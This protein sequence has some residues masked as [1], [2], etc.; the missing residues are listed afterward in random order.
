M[1]RG[2]YARQ[3]ARHAL[4]WASDRLCWLGIDIRYGRVLPRT[5]LYRVTFAAGHWLGELGWRLR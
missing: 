5:G 2:G 3:L 1:R 4:W